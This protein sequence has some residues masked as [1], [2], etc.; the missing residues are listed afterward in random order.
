[1]AANW[2]RQAIN[3]GFCAGAEFPWLELVI[4][5]GSSSPTTGGFCERNGSGLLRMLRGLRPDSCTEDESE[6]LLQEEKMS[7]SGLEEQ[8]TQN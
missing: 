5:R 3:H 6:E 8:E 7:D 1:M 2:G 4:I